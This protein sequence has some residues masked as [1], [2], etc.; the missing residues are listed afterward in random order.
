MFLY[1][2]DE[3][4]KNAVYDDDISSRRRW[5]PQAAPA[6]GGEFG[7]AKKTRCATILLPAVLNALCCGVA[8]KFDDNGKLYASAIDIAMLEACS[9]TRAAGGR[10]A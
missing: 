1:A 7:D 2:C 5:R 9:R 8:H 3:L 10:A 6:G 4:V